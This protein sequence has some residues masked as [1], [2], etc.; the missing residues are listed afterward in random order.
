MST[1]TPTNAPEPRPSST[2]V[3]VRDGVIAPEVFMVKRHET[4]SFGSAYAFPGGVLE[5]DD[6]RVH[7]AL[8]GRS[9]GEAD[10]LLETREGLSYFSA[11]V[12]ELFEES[13]VLLG[14][15]TLGDA[16]LAAARVAL[17]N[18][19]LSWR[20]FVRSHAPDLHSDQLHYFSF[21]ITPIGL[22]KRYTTRFFMARLPVGQTASHCGGELVDSTWMTANNVLAASRDKSMRVHYPTRKTLQRIASCAST[23]DLLQ[24]ADACSQAG[25]VCDE[26]TIPPE[27][28]L[29]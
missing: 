5:P 21:W 14:E 8:R 19:E 3:L 28:L 26:P 7:K 27:R 17:N 6:A 13:G 22:P 10:A 4:S 16:E 23:D 24:W 9:A 11:A 2:V 15:S 29:G 25:V 18:D 1:S 20:E 12:R